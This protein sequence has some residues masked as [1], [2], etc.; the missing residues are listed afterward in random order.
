MATDLTGQVALRDLRKS[1]GPLRVLDGVSLSIA[2]GEV[3]VVCGPSGCG[4]STL[5]RCIN[6][7]EEIESGTIEVGGIVVDPRDAEAL[8]KVRRATGLVF[9][10]FNLFP[11]MTVIDNIVIAPMKVLGMP[12]RQARDE[13]RALLAGVGI[14][15]KADVY[16]FQL[17][18]GQRQRV[19]IAR[20]LAMKPSVMMFDEPTSAL[21]PEMREEVLNVIRSVHEERGMTMIVV[22]HEIGF[23]RSVGTRAIL[24]DRGKIAEEGPA[25]EFFDRPATER[26]RRFVT[27]IK[28]G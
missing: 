21:D 10:N 4:K 20:A 27:A 16:P 13:A 24:M 14:P 8:R 1:Y 6:G 26:A 7:L 22:T 9:Q 23:A 3:F 12:A 11:H 17:S 19:A 5:L 18:G 28:N 25:R 2:R 15:E